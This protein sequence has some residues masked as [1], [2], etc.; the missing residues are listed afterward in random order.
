MSEE[1]LRFVDTIHRDRQVSKEVIFT[2]IEMALVSAA[3]K[4]FDQEEGIEVNIDRD[5]GE[6][7]A[8]CDG[9]KS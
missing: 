7:S 8:S 4:S 9:S 2:G 5:T 1:I 6:I 3:Q